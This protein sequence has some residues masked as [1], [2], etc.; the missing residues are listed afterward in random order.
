MKQSKAL[1][2]NCGA[3]VISAGVFSRT[4]GGLRLDDFHSEELEYDFSNEDIWMPTLLAAL[5]QLS[6]T[7]RLPSDATLIAPGFQILTKIIRVPIVE[8]GRQA[9]TIAFEVAQNIPYP[10]SDTVWSTH[11]IDDDGVELE[12]LAAVWKLESANQL[13][14]GVA[15]AG[16]NPVRASAA[17]ALDYNAFRF[18]QPDNNDDVLVLNIGARSSNLLFV[19]GEE[20]SVRSIMLGGNALTQSLADNLGRSFTEAEAIKVNHFSGADVQD[21]EATVKTIKTNADA[22]MRRLSTE[23]TRSVVTFRRSKP[24]YKPKLLLLTGRGSLLP[25]LSGYL[26]EKVKVD[27]DYFN[28]TES[29]ELGG[30]VDAEMVNTHFYQMSELVGEA[31]RSLVPNGA[32]LDILP[33]AISSHLEFA[34][35]KPILIAA[36][37]LLPI[38]GIFPILSAQQELS[39]LNDAQA[40][41]RAAIAPLERLKGEIADESDRVDAISS[42]INQ[43]ESLVAAKN[44]WINFFVDIQQRLIATDDVWLDSLRVVRSGGGVGQPLKLELKG[45]MVSQ[46]NPTDPAGQQLVQRVNRLL[47]EF[48]ESAFISAVEGRRFNPTEGVL[49]FE[50]TLSIN[51]EKPL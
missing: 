33:Q 50:F 17:A 7:R 20:W 46:A 43:L 48:R 40:D 23:I 15:S 12:L 36:A 6:A 16:Y 37:V 14:E 27:V 32:D 19:S 5:R 24:D 8:Q 25:D 47:N 2:I 31:A 10:L 21:D 29:L 1:I 9:Q 49:E 34:R 13:C 38:A 11:Q 28:P 44:N 42:K 45:R 22:W 51:P 4:D 35:K 26:S 3:S 30:G 39:A 18:A 41:I